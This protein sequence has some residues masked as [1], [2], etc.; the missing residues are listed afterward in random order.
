MN[1]NSKPEDYIRRGTLMPKPTLDD[2]MKAVSS[3]AAPSMVPDTPP[4]PPPPEDVPDMTQLVPSSKRLLIAKM[5]ARH[6]ELGEQMGAMKKEREKLT[7]AIKPLM[8]E[9]KLGKATWGDYHLA[10]YNTPRSF[11]DPKQLL[12]HGVQPSVIAACTTVKDSYSLRISRGK[13][14]DGE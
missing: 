11:L 3:G 14:G 12:S 4:P 7:D 8:G 6:A 13:D 1:R 2:R 10:Y 9:L 5:I